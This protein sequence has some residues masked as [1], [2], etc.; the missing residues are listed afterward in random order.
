MQYSTWK[1]KDKSHPLATLSNKEKRK[2]LL[3]V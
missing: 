3:V 1:E 2:H